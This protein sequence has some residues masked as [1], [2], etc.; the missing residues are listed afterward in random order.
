M[1]IAATVIESNAKM[2][3]KN[4]KHYK[5]LPNLDLLEYPLSEV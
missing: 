4:Q 2:F 1:L 3:S 5:F